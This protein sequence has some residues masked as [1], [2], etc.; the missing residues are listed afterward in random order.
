M[1]DK[2]VDSFC[3]V[4]IPSP[5]REFKDMHQKQFHVA[6]FVVYLTLHS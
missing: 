6:F 3:S 4:K 2:D 5:Y 1:R